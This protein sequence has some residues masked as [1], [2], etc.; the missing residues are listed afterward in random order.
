MATLEV[1]DISKNKIK[2]FPT[3]FGNLIHL[4]V[5]SISKN[6][7]MHLPKYFGEMRNLKVFKAGMGVCVF[8]SRWQSLGLATFGN[9][10]SFQGRK[11]RNLG[12]KIT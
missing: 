2:R 12:G 7:F 8:T 5:M 9:D 1:L 11:W 6:R 10:G 4:R 3:D